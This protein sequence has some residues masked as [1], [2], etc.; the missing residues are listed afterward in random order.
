MKMSLKSTASSASLLPGD[1]APDFT[2]TSVLD[3]KEEQV[4]AF[5]LLFLPFLAALR[6][7]DSDFSPKCSNSQRVH[8]LLDSESE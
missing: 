8:T 4:K 1:R 5:L 2:L 3:N 7:L 6:P